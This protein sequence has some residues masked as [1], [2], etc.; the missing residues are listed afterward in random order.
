MLYRMLNQRDL[1][2]APLPFRDDER[3]GFA[4]VWNKL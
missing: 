4:A 1:G 3:T 2:T